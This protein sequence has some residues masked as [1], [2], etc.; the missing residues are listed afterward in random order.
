[1]CSST[2]RKTTSR[3]ITTASPTACCGRS[4]TT[5]STCRNIPAPTPAATCGS[6]ACSPIGLSPLLRDDDVVWVHDYHLMVLGRELRSRGHRNTIGF[7]LHTPCAPPDILQALPHHRAILG[8]L[9]HYDL[10][11][12]QTENDRDNFAHY[13]VSQGRDADPGGLRVRRPEGASR[14]LPG[15]HRD[16]GLYAPRA[17]RRALG[18]GRA[19]ARKPQRQPPRARRRPARLFERH[20]RPDQGVRTAAREQSRMARQ[21][22]ACCRSRRRAVPRSGNMARS[23]PKSPASSAR[24]TAVSATPPGRPSATSTSPIRAPFSPASTGP[25]TSAW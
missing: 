9:A 15:Q 21:S 14:R 7:F 25:P 2:C 16:Q 24:S 8:G 11:G 4:S 18:D 12:F 22:D 10:V 23:K 1:M 3:N 13:L 6:I 19:G 5:A 20:T 17:Q